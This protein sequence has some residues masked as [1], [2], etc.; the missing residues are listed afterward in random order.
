MPNV[1]DNEFDKLFQ[2]AAAHIA[3]EFDPED[4]D[5]LAQR[6][7]REEKAARARST[8]LYA[9]VAL[10]LL[11]SL[12]SHWQ[13]ATQNNVGFGWSDTPSSAAQGTSTEEKNADTDKT[14]IQIQS[15]SLPT[16]ATQDENGE[17]AAGTK[18]IIPEQSDKNA[19]GESTVQKQ[20]TASVVD[21]KET[22]VTTVID[23]KTTQEQKS[24]SP[25]NANAQQRVVNS[26]K[27][28]TSDGSADLAGKSKKLQ[29]TRP[30]A[31][32]KQNEAKTQHE[33][34]PRQSTEKSASDDQAKTLNVN[35]DS[36]PNASASSTDSGNASPK[37]NRATVQ[38]NSV[39]L[40][41]AGSLASN[42]KQVQQNTSTEI[43]RP[44][45]TD[46]IQKNGAEKTTEAETT[47]TPIVSAATPATTDQPATAAP[48]FTNE[49]QTPAST[50]RPLSHEPIVIDT[51]DK[52][53][54][55][56][57]ANATDSTGTRVVYDEKKNVT[58]RWF[59]K[60]PVSPD[61]SS[62]NYETPGKPGINIGLLAEYSLSRHFFVS[63][64]AIWSKKIYDKENPDKTY[65]S[66]GYSAKAKSM[67]G[68]CR[69]LDIPIN[70]TYYIFPE[71]KT[72]L[73]VTVGSSSYIMLNEEYVYT[74]WANQRDYEYTENFSNKNREWFSM[75]NIS[76]GIQRMVGERF[77]VQAEPFIKAPV[78]GVGEGKVNLASTGAFFSLKYRLSK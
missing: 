50:N 32:T 13:N 47:N 3:P 72:S 1:N 43:A 59:L 76:F 60:L 10:L 25:G 21:A 75:L 66:G 73:F 17:N 33:T 67:R 18:N 68:D 4:W 61:F 6:L 51:T 53:V 12:G 41:S 45:T 11:S 30:I 39:A 37:T 35:K 8:S 40:A 74:V 36:S 28:S 44:E 22:K 19:A 9:V 42:K 71:A 70:V 5:R 58:H 65:S 29:S 64:G 48:A 55:V 14:S 46:A 63:T 23:G 16:K 34:T 62:I 56:R 20:S 77:F 78:S 24:S 52:I 49:H 69:V 27:K 7:E 15:E 57:L 38:H 31:F 54:P 26:T 2:E